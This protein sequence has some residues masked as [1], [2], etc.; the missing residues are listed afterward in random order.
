MEVKANIR[1]PPRKRRP[2]SI[3][4]S[5]DSRFRGNDLTFH[6]T[7][8]VILRIDSRGGLPLMNKKKTKDIRVFFLQSEA[9]DP[10]S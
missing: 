10:G 4:E 9:K 6:T 5:M 3:Q 1:H 8:I 2:L 7:K